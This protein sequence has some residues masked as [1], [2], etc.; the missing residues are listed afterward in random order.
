MIELRFCK[1][2]LYPSIAVNLRLDD[3]K[4]CSSC[5]GFEKMNS[6]PESFWKERREQ[7]QKILDQT[8]KNN[9]S[10]YDCLVPVSG[11]KDSYYQTHIIVKEFKLKPLLVT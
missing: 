2:C 4:V 11:G 9:K 7:F 6:L 10:N 3:D 1:K 8:L 5:R